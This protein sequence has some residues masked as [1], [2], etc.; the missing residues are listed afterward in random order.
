MYFDRDKNAWD[1]WDEVKGRKSTYDLAYSGVSRWKVHPSRDEWFA[2]IE[3]F[4]RSY[5]SRLWIV[6][7]LLAG[8][9]VDIRCGDVHIASDSLFS[10]LKYRHLAF[11]HKENH[12][13]LPNE[14]KIR[15]YTMILNN[16]TSHVKGQLF[17]ILAIF[18]DN[19]CTDP[20]DKLYGVMSLLDIPE[21]EIVV[22]YSKSVKEV[23]FDVAQYWCGRLK[24]SWIDAKDILPLASVCHSM[25]PDLLPEENVEHF[26]G[27]LLEQ[28]KGLVWDASNTW[29]R[30]R[31]KEYIDW[32]TMEIAIKDVLNAVDEW[33]RHSKDLID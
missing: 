17:T 33:N 13:L 5:W 3:L 15:T 28:T 16:P 18:H 31:A 29:L 9:P 26:K 22:D 10:F 25:L 12:I 8:P 7:E 4:R 23:F 14:E 24:V 2:I 20:R 27:W 1:D 32:N 21:G 30:N 6:Q 11:G 19:D